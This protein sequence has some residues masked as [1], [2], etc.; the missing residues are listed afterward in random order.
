MGK[1]VWAKIT[2]LFKGLNKEAYLMIMLGYFSLSSI[3]TYVVGSYLKH[4][5]EVLLASTNN[6]CLYG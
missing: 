2:T 1:L 5:A 4:L 3:E 6:I